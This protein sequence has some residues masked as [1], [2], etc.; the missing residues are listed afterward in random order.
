[1][2]YNNNFGFDDGSNFGGQPR[3][4]PDIND[5]WNFTQGKSQPQQDRY[6]P[7]PVQQSDNFSVPSLFGGVDQRQGSQSQQGFRDPMMN[8]QTSGAPDY[9]T[10]ILNQQGAG[11]GNEMYTGM[12]HA[13]PQ[14][15]FGPSQMPIPGQDFPMAGGQ[16]TGGADDW[17]RQLDPL[18]QGAMHNDPNAKKALG[19]GD[20]QAP[21]WAAENLRNPQTNQD[22]TDLYYFLNSNKDRIKAEQ[23]Q[24]TNPAAYASTGYVNYKNFLP[25]FYAAANAQRLP[26]ELAGTIQDQADLSRR[27]Y[28]LAAN[29][30]G[31]YGN[32]AD[33]GM[34]FQAGR[35]LA[36]Q[37]G[38]GDVYLTNIGGQNALVRRLQPLPPQMGGGGYGGGGG[39]GGRG[40]SPGGGRGPY[41][42]ATSGPAAGA[43]GGGANG[44]LVQNKQTGAYG[45]QDQSGVV[46]PI[47]PGPG[48]GSGEMGLAGLTG[49]G[50][51]Y[52]G[53]SGGVD[54][55]QFPTAYKNGGGGP[56]AGPSGYT[57]SEYDNSY[58]GETYSPPAYG[59]GLVEGGSERGGSTSYGRPYP[60]SPSQGT[61]YLD[62]GGNLVMIDG[63]GSAIPVSS[64]PEYQPPNIQYNPQ[65]EAYYIGPSGLPV[66]I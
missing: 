59:P 9:M 66:Y 61:T 29:P 4:L 62:D 40:Y 37:G 57:P 48:G 64:Q 60:V 24:P 38:A 42:T 26:N 30:Y 13:A 19:F 53:K 32:Q 6:Y 10:D 58:P 12:G 54:Y 18:I 20:A 7:Q 2:A 16:G 41:P 45:I 65:G 25:N 51:G 50:E 35:K 5:L 27:G 28:E 44:R 63:R 17:T 31:Q 8:W 33:Q 3:A 1:M 43:A 14:T 11:G 56:Q 34:A 49:N 23:G 22:W 47:Q 46:R 21:W 52:Y 39:A 55:S 36:G 15:P